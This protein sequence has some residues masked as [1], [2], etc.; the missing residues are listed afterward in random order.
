MKD[1]FF[2]WLLDSLKVVGRSS[3]G[4]LLLFLGCAYVFLWMPDI[5]LTVISI[6]HHRSIITH[7]LFPALLFLLFGRRLGA[8]PMAGA[9]I[10][11]SVHLS[12]DLLSPMVGYAQIWL[13]APFKAPLGLFSYI[14]LGGNAVVGFALAASMARTA[15][16]RHLALPIVALVAV[17]GGTMYGVLNEGSILAVLAV[18][19]IVVL[20]LFPEWFIQRRWR[21]LSRYGMLE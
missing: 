1:R 2:R 12:C 5:D 3:L 9:L 13:P 10:G 21:H 7:S 8:A 14:W 20:S 11:T 17:V 15:F 6:L 16:P 19:V 4:R 18:L